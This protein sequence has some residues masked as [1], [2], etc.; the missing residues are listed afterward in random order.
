MNWDPGRTDVGTRH[1]PG[2]QVECP[3]LSG[4][5]IVL[6]RLVDPE[7][8]GLEVRG[9]RHPRHTQPLLPAKRGDDLRGQKMGVEDQVPGLL[10]EKADEGPKIESFHRQAKTVRAIA[11]RA[12]GLI[13][14][15]VEVAQNVRG[16]IDQ[17]Q[18]GLAVDTA[19]GGV[20]QGQHVEVSDRGL[21][22]NLT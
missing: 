20:R 22:H 12:T 19:K 17:V 13:H 7:P 6:A 9:D 3:F 18:V 10:F 16:L 4:G 8:V 5:E 14:Q 11:A 21:G 15:I 2:R 1:A